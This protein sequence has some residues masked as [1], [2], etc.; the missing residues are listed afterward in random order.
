MIGDTTHYFCE[1]NLRVQVS[2]F[3]YICLD[4]V[5]NYIMHRDIM[6]MY[7]INKLLLL[8]LLLHSQS[9]HLLPL[10]SKH[11]VQLVLELVPKNT[12]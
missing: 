3:V 9:V 2:P 5:Y 1:H 6:Y 4:M 7:T 8:L 12:F 10:G 11:T